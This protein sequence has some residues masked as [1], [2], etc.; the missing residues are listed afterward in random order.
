MTLIRFPVFLSLV[1]IIWIPCVDGQNVDLGVIDDPLRVGIS[2]DRLPRIS[3]VVRRRIESGEIAGAVTLVAR[4]GRVVHF[5]PQ[6]VLDVESKAPMSRDALFR[7]ASTS[8]PVTAA[9]VVMLIEEGKI[10]LTDPASRFIPEFREPK[11]AVERNGRVELVPTH[12][13]IQVLDLLTHSSGLLSGGP[14]QKQFPGDSTFPRKGDSLADFVQRI[15]P[16][17]LDFEPGSRWVYSPFGGIDTLAR[18]VEVASSKPFDVFLQERLFEPLGMKDTSFYASA[19]SQPRLAAFHA[20]KGDELKKGVYSFEFD[21][22]YTSGAAG[23]LSTAED[24]FRFGQMLANGGELDGRRVLSPRGVEMLSSNHVGE[25]FQGSLGRPDGM[26]FGF[27]VEVVVDPIQAATFRS[28]GSFGW[29]GAFG[30]QFWVDPKEGIV[31][32]FMVQASGVRTIQNDFGTA[33]MQAVGNLDSP[34]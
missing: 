23:L 7:M 27:A 25:K 30:T 33:V 31:A 13:E 19:E 29:D 1:A 15:A 3:E 26:G 8:K 6:G 10:R 9:A 20:R 11:V 5:E 12:R 17:P 24:F 2:A 32:V 4:H 34:R 22:P 14:G 28:A 16:A 21:R 18:I